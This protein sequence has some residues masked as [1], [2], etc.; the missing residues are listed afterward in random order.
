MLVASSAISRT[1]GVRDAG[2]IW[3]C[4]KVH[5]GLCGIELC[6]YNCGAVVWVLRWYRLS[7]DY[8]NI[9]VWIFNN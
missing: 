1:G 7:V 6:C 9:L 5:I 2:W 3:T 4:Y 8:G